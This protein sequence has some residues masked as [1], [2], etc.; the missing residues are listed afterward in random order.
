MNPNMN[1]NDR[2]NHSKTVVMAGIGFLLLAAAFTFPFGNFGQKF[3]S[4]QEEEQPG[5]GPAT[6]PT[7]VTGGQDTF[8][9]N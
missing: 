2:K 6:T 1:N 9:S 3:A 7:V 8:T 4:G 5:A